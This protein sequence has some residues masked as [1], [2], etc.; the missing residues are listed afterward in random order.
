MNNEKLIPPPDFMYKQAKEAFELLEL[1]KKQK[2][3]QRLKETQ[4]MIDEHVERCTAEIS[5]DIRWVSEKGGF[6]SEISID[7]LFRPKLIYS[8]QRAVLDVVFARFR[9]A[10]YVIK[11]DNPNPHYVMVF[12]VS[13]DMKNKE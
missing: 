10:G 6:I 2:E 3:E 7:T 5:E 13:W 4:Q 11:A 12:T 1:K 9:K 8:M